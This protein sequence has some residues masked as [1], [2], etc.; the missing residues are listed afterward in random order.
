[1]SRTKRISA[2]TA[3]VILAVVAAW[4]LVQ[5]LSADDESRGQSQPGEMAGMEG[6]QGMEGMDMS[7]SGDSSVLLM[8]DQIERFGITFGT[9]EYRTLTDEVRTVGIVAFDETRVA[10]VTL[11]FSGFVE[12]LYVDFTG[13]P[14]RAGQPLF[15]IYSAELLAAQEELLL[16]AK[17]EG[18]LAGTQVP[19][20]PAGSSRLIAA[21]RQRLRLWD[22]SDAQIEEILRSGR[23]QRTLTLLAPVSGVVVEKNVLAG[24]AVQAGERLYTIADLSE[25][26]VEAELRELDAALAHIGSPAMVEVG[27]FPGRPIAGRVAF[28]Y[29]TLEEQARTVKA[30]ISIANHAGRL[31]PGMYATVRIEVPGQTV[32]TAPASA[33]LR[34][35]ERAL[36]F[37][38]MGEGRIMPRQ[39]RLGRVAGDYAEVLSGLEP[40]QRLVTSA[41]FLLDSESNLAEVMRGMM[42]QMNTSDVGSADMRGMDMRGTDMKRPRREP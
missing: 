17:L 35:G 15:E 33:V 19:G 36:V 18:S 11:K 39:I 23:A 41:Q 26:W 1:M 7:T 20:V 27:A 5:T 16:A 21:A 12:R 40:G 6:M 22:I 29:P 10:A 32:L 37:V 31:K 30:R 42:S 4:A 8:P 14:V 38:D 13:K 24:Q 25:V 3:I 9:V 34:T 2:A 28:I